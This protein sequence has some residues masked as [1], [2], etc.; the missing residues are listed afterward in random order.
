MS[1]QQHLRRLADATRYGLVL[2]ILEVAHDW[3]F[4]NVS[5]MQ[6]Y[7]MFSARRGRQAQ[8]RVRGLEQRSEATCQRRAR[9]RSDHDGRLT[10]LDRHFHAV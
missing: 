7:L 3:R 1:V 6:A 4:Q 9:Q 2:T 8:Q 10:E 5:A